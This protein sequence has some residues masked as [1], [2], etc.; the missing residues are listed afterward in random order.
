MKVRICR[1]CAY[2]IVRGSQRLCKKCISN[3]TVDI[4]RFTQCPMGYTEADIDWAEQKCIE[5]A[6]R[7]RP[8]YAR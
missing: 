5:D 6:I 3:R 2:C 8:L 7:T 1:D 4:R